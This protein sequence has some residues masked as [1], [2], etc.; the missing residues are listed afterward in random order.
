MHYY[1]RSLSQYDM[2]CALV[3]H[4][5]V[6]TLTCSS[7]P[8]MRFCGMVSSGDDGRDFNSVVSTLVMWS[9]ATRGRMALA[10]ISR[11]LYTGL[12]AHLH[13]V[14]DSSFH[15]QIPVVKFIN[16]RYCFKILY[17]WQSHI[18]MLT[19]RCYFSNEKCIWKQ[20]IFC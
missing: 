5:C 1:Y 17:F 6:G 10:A 4:G 20:C 7:A 8:W 2:L 11:V 13:S 14:E 12:L 3:T 19:L 16:P 9:L 18:M 15:R